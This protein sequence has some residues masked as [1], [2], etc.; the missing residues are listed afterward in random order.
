MH[1]SAPL[2]VRKAHKSFTVQTKQGNEY[3]IPKGHTLAS[4]VVINNNMP[5]TYKDPEVYDPDRFG[6]A[7]VEDKIGGRF[8][9]PS[10]GGGGKHGCIGEAYAYMQIKVIWSHLLRNFDLKLMFPVPEPDWSKFIQLP[11]RQVLVSYKRRRLP[12]T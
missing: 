11:P 3:E 12:C 9:Y 8:S 4:P 7:R 10:F 2:L 1:P 5:H 6:P